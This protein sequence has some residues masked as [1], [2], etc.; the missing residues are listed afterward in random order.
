MSIFGP[1]RDLLDFLQESRASR[2]WYSTA[3]ANIADLLAAAWDK[4][5]EAGD[6]D[7]HWGEGVTRNPYRKGEA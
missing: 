2:Q 3:P 5:Y 7:R 1:S 4:G 6:S